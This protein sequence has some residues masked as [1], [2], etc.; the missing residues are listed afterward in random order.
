MKRLLIICLSLALLAAC[1]PAGVSV[2]PVTGLPQG[3]GAYPWWND[4]VFYEVFVRSF[5]DSNGDGI[6]DFNGLAQKLDY[7]ND[8][9]PKTN[10][11]LGVTGLWLMPVNPASSYHGY[12]VTDYYTTNPQ[13]GTL[14]DF[15]NLVAAAHQRGL[16]VIIDLVLNHTSSQH[17]WFLDSQDPGSVYRNWYIWSPDEPG[18]AGWHA[19][20][21]GYYLGIFEAGMPDLNYTNPAVTQEMQAVARFWLQETGIDGFR[22]DAAK[23]L[24]EQ[25]TLQSH[26]PATLAWLDD[27]RKYARSVEPQALNVGEVWD[28][29]VA[30]S[31]YINAGAVDLAFDFDL[32]QAYVSSARLGNA[33][34]ASQVLSRDLRL[35][36]APSGLPGQFASFLSNHDQAR[37][38]SMLGEDTGKAKVAASLL[39]TTPGVPFMYYGEE[40]GM[41]GLKPDERLRTPMQWSG[42]NQAGFSQGEAWEAPNDDYAKRNVA[43]QTNDPDSLLAHYRALLRLRSA[44]AALRIGE[45]QQ[46]ES[47]QPGVWAFLRSA[48][49]PNAQETV[50][51][52]I[53]LSAKCVTN[54]NLSLAAGPFSERQRAVQLLAWESLPEGLPPLLPNLQGGFDAY[55]P[56]L[57][58][59]PF[60]TL[61]LQIRPLKK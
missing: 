27:F 33:L 15:K 56:V 50:L 35:F 53:N 7:L 32:A 40:I 55:Q 46:V 13:Y 37:P 54:C 21:N 52:V 16:R 43:A 28:N 45:F 47:C 26:S 6:G 23:F 10:T 61:I 1:R 9:N 4:T 59:P 19:A 25:G 14:D 41:L 8:G 20:P 36:A 49:E 44:H 29:S 42:K 30:V 24:I 2:A 39:L 3:S 38:M 34:Q 12:N 48:G 11:D 22:L 51:V 31:Q 57:E 18:G 58:L 5:Y 17:P 60:S